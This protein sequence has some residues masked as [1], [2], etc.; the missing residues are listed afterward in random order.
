MELLIYM[1]SGNKADDTTQGIQWPNPGDLIVANPDGWPWGVQELA[2]SCFRILRVLDSDLTLQTLLG[3]QLPA[4]VQDTGPWN[5]RQIGLVPANA[6]GGIAYIQFMADTMRSASIF[7]A[8]KITG[9]DLA[10]ISSTRTPLVSQTV[11]GS[12]VIG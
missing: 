12:A 10:K 6:L 9:F 5:Y 2:L 4:N 8:T 7:D 11:I 3:P 1:Q